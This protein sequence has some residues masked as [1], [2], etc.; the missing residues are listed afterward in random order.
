MMKILG[1]PNLLHSPIAGGEIFSKLIQPQINKFLLIHSK[2]SKEF[3]CF[4]TSFCPWTITTLCLRDKTPFG[5][6]EHRSYPLHL[7]TY[8]YLNH[9]IKK[10]TGYSERYVHGMHLWCEF[11]GSNIIYTFLSIGFLM[12]KSWILFYSWYLVNNNN[13][14][15]KYLMWVIS[16]LGPGFAREKFYSGLIIAAYA[17]KPYFLCC[18]IF[19]FSSSVFSNRLPLVCLSFLVK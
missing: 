17:Q 6:I 5:C 11:C 2:F 16:Q 14:L 12:R 13:I 9:D 10:Y 15:F 4:S 1:I 19:C 7:F 3:I 8:L 18:V